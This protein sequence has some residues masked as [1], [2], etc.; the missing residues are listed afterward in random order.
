MGVAPCS[1]VISY[2]SGHE[3]A[4]LCTCNPLSCGPPICATDPPL[5]EVGPGND[6][7]RDLQERGPATRPTPTK[8][9][10]PPPPPPP[11]RQPPVMPSRPLKSALR[12][13]NRLTERLATSCGCAGAPRGI[14]Y[15]A[16][17]NEW[18]APKA[19]VPSQIS[20]I[21]DHHLPF[22]KALRRPTWG[23]SLPLYR[24]PS[25]GQWST[26]SGNVKPWHAPSRFRDRTSLVAL[27]STSGH[28]ERSS[29]IQGYRPGTDTGAL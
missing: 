5:G 25:P 10:D 12:T 19:T 27:A 21:Q 22:L 7:R 24:R 1:V 3:P 20:N 14:E 26:P 8:W 16:G 23:W 2:W 6:C 11:N 4:R 13:P 29:P 15:V 17:A 28:R 9:V 18:A